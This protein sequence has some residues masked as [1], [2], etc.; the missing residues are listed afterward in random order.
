M[1]TIF[2]K[3]RNTSQEFINGTS[4]NDDIYPGGG[5]DVVNGGAGVDTVHV[6]GRSNQFK[7]V[8]ED[9]VVYI[10]S[11]SAASAYSERV[12][13]INIEKVQFWDGLVDLRVS[14]VF[15][16]EDSSVFIAGGPGSDTMVY[17]GPRDSYIVEKAGAY[18]FVQTKASVGMDSGYRSD[19]L[20]SIETIQFADQ[21]VSFSLPQDSVAG[22]ASRLISVVL[23]PQFLNDS[24]LA[25]IVVG[26]LEQGSTMQ[27]LA[28]LGASMELFVSL[29][30]GTSNEDFVGLI[31]QNLMGSAPS[32]NDVRLL[33]SLIDSG[34]YS[35]G[36][37]AV[38][39]VT[40]TDSIGYVDF[41]GLANQGWA[42]NLVS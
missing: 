7:L 9:G 3:Y 8:A 42:Y 5:W 6:E 11:L 17:S 13:L 27:E 4:E 30:G 12:Q 33:T 36:S 21:A 28:S 18:T 39:A 24:A 19:R 20:E 26:A 25:G 1:A 38:A 22:Q 35:K 31:Y 14:K 23:G 34:V 10:D 29:A 41:T 40:L 16:D 2:G 37:L 15:R 32:E